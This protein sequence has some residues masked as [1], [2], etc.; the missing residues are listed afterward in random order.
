MAIGV[1]HARAWAEWEGRLVDGKFRLL[2]CLHSTERSAVFHTERPQGELRKAAI[3]L[4]ALDDLGAEAQLARWKASALLL[5]PHLMR[6]FE[7]GRVQ[8]GDLSCAYVVMEYAEE[9]LSQVDRALTVAEASDMLGAAL[10]VLTYLQ[11]KGFAHGHLKPSNFMAV[12]DQLKISSDT[13][14]PI[15]EWSS[16]L[17]VPSQSDPP[18]ITDQGASSAGDIWSL[19]FSLVNALTLPSADAVPPSSL[20]NLPALF[21]AVI[22]GC[23]RRDPKQRWTVPNLSA[24][25]QRNVET[26]PPSHYTSSYANRWNRRYLLAAVVVGIAV[27]ATFI[28]SRV[29]GH[30]SVSEP[31]ASA[32]SILQNEPTATQ[33]QAASVAKTTVQGTRGVVQDILQKVLPDVAAQA[34]NTIRGKINIRIRINVDATGSVINAVNESPGS[35]RFFGNLA[36]QAARQWKFAHNSSREWILRFQFVRDPN[37]AVSVQATPSK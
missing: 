4:I 17:D 6:L 18:E 13:I 15:G 31:S 30:R 29:I 12:G 37:N 21:R 5:H 28:A 8:L 33:S 14:R 9:D 11:N 16:D 2:E 22:T 7:M 35:S 3:K 20:D 25:L 34:R 19:G 32:S 27:A 10:K 24:F 36:L 1:K 26:P 23:L